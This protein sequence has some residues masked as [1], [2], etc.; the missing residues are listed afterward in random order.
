MAARIVKSTVNHS[1]RMGIPDREL[2][3]LVCTA[4]VDLKAE[5]VLLYDLENRSSITDYIVICSGRSQ[6]H[7]RGICDKIE[8]R[9][10]A[11]GVRPSTI[12]G[13][14]EG[15]WV[16]L[17]CGVGIAHVFHPESRA[18]YD[19]EGLLRGSPSER[20]EPPEAVRPI[21]VDEGAAPA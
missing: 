5:Q 4:V 21:A 1:G 20:I 13:Y 7:V 19:L 3:D 18:Y 16:L 12:E 2:A 6:G 14:R 10:K 15:S 8:E 11:H 9:L 17:D